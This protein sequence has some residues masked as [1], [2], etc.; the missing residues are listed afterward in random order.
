MAVVTFKGKEKDHS[1]RVVLSNSQGVYGMTK[2][3][4]NLLLECI[5]KNDMFPFYNRKVWRDLSKKL[6][7]EQHNE[8]E[9]CRRKGKLTTKNNSRRLLVHHIFEVKDYP[10][11]ALS[12]WVVINGE[13]KQNLI[14]LCDE[15][16]ENEH[17][18]FGEKKEKFTNQER[19]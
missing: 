6:I 18:R 5:A 8:C 16:H 12:K 9:M 13:R 17:K 4:Y 2:E 7:K 19:W 1:H 3:I 11:Y 14:V 10:Q 15:C